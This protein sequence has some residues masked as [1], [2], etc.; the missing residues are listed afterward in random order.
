[1]N[2]VSNP[3]Q[4]KRKILPFFSTFVFLTSGRNGHFIL[5]ELFFN[6]SFQACGEF[7]FFYSRENPAKSMSLHIGYSAWTLDDIFE[8]EPSETNPLL[9]ELVKPEIE[10]T[11]DGSN[12][13][14]NYRSYNSLI[15]NL[16]CNDVP[17]SNLAITQD[18][19]SSDGIFKISA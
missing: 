16:F 10:G 15:E 9:V 13:L 14:F 8:V 7:V 1:D 6:V 12:N 18:L 11:I 5:V 4:A 2:C 3:I 17:P 19:S